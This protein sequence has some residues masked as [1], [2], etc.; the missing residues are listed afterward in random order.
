MSKKLILKNLYIYL[1]GVPNLSEDTTRRQTILNIL[2]FF[3]IMVF[4]AINIIRIIDNI[5]YE[6]KRGLPLWSTLI[7]LFI[8]I[9]LLK[10]SQKNKINLA[11]I[12]LIAIYSVPMIFCLMIWGAD[13][14]AGLLLSVIIIMMTAALMGAQSA[15]IATAIISSVLISLTWLQ[16]IGIIAIQDYWREE[17]NQIVDA[18]VYSILLLIAASIVW[19][20][21]HGISQSLLRAKRSE[22]ALKEEMDSLEIKIIQRTKE[23]RMAEQEKINQ[24]YRLAEFGKLS[25]GIFHDLMN[26]L[27]AVSLNLE[28]IKNESKNDIQDSKDILRAKTY[29]N[30]AMIAANK[31]NGLISGVRKQIQKE[32]NSV[33]FML[34]KEIEEIIQILSYKANRA[35][36]KIIFTNNYNLMLV[37]DPVKFGQVII[38]LLANA[39]DANE[40]YAEIKNIKINLEKKEDNIIITVQDRGVGINPSYINKI[41]EPYFSTKSKTGQGFGI[42]L[43][44]TKDIVEKTFK[45][46]I[47]VISN[48]NVGTIFTVILPIKQ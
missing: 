5:I 8:F 6:E 2:L 19:L 29:L 24:L 11:S 32:S 16:N 3:S 28:H 38:N 35:N 45:G 36:I 37:G 30:Q 14:P 17:N 47:N 46:H 10:L 7:I 9:I 27:T 21:A 31:M 42:G 23:L 39:I 20:F 34:N 13:L 22:K 4:T 43:S 1:Q 40:D 18:I 12:L 25:S 26:P 33:P 48:H 15:F 41:F 44:L